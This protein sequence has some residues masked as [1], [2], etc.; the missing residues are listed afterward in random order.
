[1]LAPSQNF[2]KEDEILDLIMSCFK[3]FI[4]KATQKYD[5]DMCVKNNNEKSTEIKYPLLF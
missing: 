5:G 3:N 1:M 2:D 4:L